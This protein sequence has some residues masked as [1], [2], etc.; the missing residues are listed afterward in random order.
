LDL[1]AA[2]R[3]YLHLACVHFAR[4]L[5]LNDGFSRLN[6]SELAAALRWSLDEFRSFDSQIEQRIFRD[7]EECGGALPDVLVDHAVR[8][9]GKQGVAAGDEQGGF[10][11]LSFILCPYFCN[12]CHVLKFEGFC[13]DL[14][15]CD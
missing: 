7:L 4:E 1:Q 14:N 10:L 5:A 12:F 2:R 13:S 15:N 9:G 3:R 6:S 8:I 11:L